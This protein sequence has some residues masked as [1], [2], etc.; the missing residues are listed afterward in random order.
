MRYY[1][2]TLQDF[3]TKNKNSSPTQEVLSNFKQSLKSYVANISDSKK[4]SEEHQKNI[5]SSFLSKTFDYSC[6]T[7]N[8]ID[9]AI[10]EDSTPKVLYTRSA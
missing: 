7:R 5:L 10:Y 6:N 1:F 9:L 8:K 3:L 4:E 2:I